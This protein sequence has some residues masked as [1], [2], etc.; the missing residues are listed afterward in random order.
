MLDIKNFKRRC[1]SEASFRKTAYFSDFVTYSCDKENLKEKTLKIGIISDQ[2]IYDGLKYEADLYPLNV[3][4]YSSI[5]RFA[6][7]DFVLITSF[8]ESVTGDWRFTDIKNTALVK[9]V[10]DSKSLGVPTVFWLTKG[11][12]YFDRYQEFAQNFDYIYCADEKSC[13]AFHEYAISANILPPCVQPL[14]FNPLKAQDMPRKA[15]EPYALFDG[16]ADIDRFEKYYE[17]LLD[18][19]LVKELRIIES[20]CLITRNRVQGLSRYSQSTLG[21]V[22][23]YQKAQLLRDCT[24]FVIGDVSISDEVDQAWTLLQGMASRVPVMLLSGKEI[25]PTKLYGAMFQGGGWRSQEASEVI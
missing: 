14:I 21:T 15:M 25:L 24:I 16:W 8:I 11:N 9:L 3:S 10:Q 18:E 13:V 7:L 20:R 23:P 12:R 4:N 1:L 19:D 2:Y 22:L 17:K 6:N 5:L